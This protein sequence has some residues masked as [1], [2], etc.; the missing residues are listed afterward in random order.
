[1]P[2][3]IAVFGSRLSE[4]LAE[5]RISQAD[6]CRLTGLASSM[7]SH[8]CNGQRIPSV[9]TAIKIA[10][11]LNTT[12]EELAL[13]PPSKAESPNT[14]NLFVGENGVT[15]KSGMQHLDSSECELYVLNMFRKLN[16]KGE[17]KVITYMED[18]LSTGKYD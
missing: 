1:M 4:K 3:E 18:L 11:A 8:Y 5:L 7:I 17:A 9:P 6:L 10:E 13:Y 12:I 2:K 14:A 16:P 15:Y